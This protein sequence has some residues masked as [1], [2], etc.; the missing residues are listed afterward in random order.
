M[1]QLIFL[2]MLCSG[3]LSKAQDADSLASDRVRGNTAIEFMRHHGII[4]RLRTNARQIA[5]YQQAG[6]T[7]MV[8]SI[9][10]KTE[11]INLHLIHALVR[12]WT[13]CPLFFIK[14]TNSEALKH[15]TIWTYNPITKVDSAILLGNDTFFVMDYGPA[16]AEQPVDDAAFRNQNKHEE[17]GTV[18]ADEALV[19]KDRMF[20]QLVRPFPYFINLSWSYFFGNFAKSKTER[21][22]EV[23]VH[24]NQFDQTVRQW[25][26]QM[27]RFY[28]RALKKRGIDVPAPED[29]YWHQKNPNRK[30]FPWIPQIEARSDSIS[31]R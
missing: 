17:S 1:K 26:D 24:S 15:D 16:M 28:G 29:V 2:L 20:K 31:K 21:L 13:F 30:Y 9:E 14:N 5:A 8:Q 7:K 4:V 22:D 6:N 3:V 25:N 11:Q 27:I 10:R 18:V 23:V 19:M 12:S